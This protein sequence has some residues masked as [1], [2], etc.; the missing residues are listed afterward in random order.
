[1]GDLE[2]AVIALAGTYVRLD[3]TGWVPHWFRRLLGRTLSKQKADIE[4]H[5][6]LGNEFYRYFL[7]RRL[8]YSCGY[9]RT[10]NDSLDLA[11]EQKIAHTVAKLDLEP[12]QRLLDIGCGWGHL[13]FHAAEVYGVT[14]LGLTLCDNQAQY[15]R[16]EAR[17]RRLPV[18]VRVMNYLE[19]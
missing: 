15:I 14:C 5:Y 18:E 4:H 16:E 3:P 2:E 9:F 19:L 11:Q 10:P 8:Q 17:K 1:E 7:D 13:M 12:K 6:G